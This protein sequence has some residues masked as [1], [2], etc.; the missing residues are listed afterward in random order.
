MV[1][2]R[3]TLNEIGVRGRVMVDRDIKT[4]PKPKMP[5]FMGTLAA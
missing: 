5:V 1:R 4:G 3:S 2:G